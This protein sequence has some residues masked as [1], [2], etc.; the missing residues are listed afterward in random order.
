MKKFSLSFVILALALSIAACSSSPAPALPDVA[1]TWTSPE[2]ES[3]Y[4]FVQD[5]SR[6]SGETYW[7]DNGRLDRVG[8]LEGTLQADG[9]AEWTTVLIEN[10]ATGK[11]TISG[12]FSQES[13][14][15]VFKVFNNDGSTRQQGQQAL[16]R[17]ITTSF[18]PQ[19]HYQKLNR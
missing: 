8:L 7:R 10:G 14:V 16:E 3:R 2:G 18:Q 12:T 15:G 1:G 4:V 6:L 9:R 11:E 17:A 5:G 13:F 19:N